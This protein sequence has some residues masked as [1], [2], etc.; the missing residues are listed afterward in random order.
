MP[1]V[2]LPDG[3]IVNFPDGMPEQEIAAAIQSLTKGDAPPQGG[4]LLDT[5]KNVGIGILKGA[6][7]SLAGIGE[8]AANA[9]AIPG[10]MPAAGNAAFRHPAFRMAESATTASND[11]QRAGKVIEGV[12]EVAVPAGAAI[13][14]IPRAGRAAAKFARVATAA[15][16]VPVNIEGPGQVALRIQQLGE[17]GAQEPRVIGKLLRRLTDPGKAPMDFEEARDFYSNVSRLS[18]NEFNSMNPI[19]Q[20]EMGNLRSAMN[21][22]LQDAAGSVGKGAEYGS[23]MKEYARAAKLKGMK[24]SLVD[25]LKRA[26]LPAG[27]AAGAYYWLKNQF[28][29][30]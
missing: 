18:A 8:L 2:H 7:S 27:G 30:E 4:G 11:A 17:R 10:V 5:A 26:A 14:A 29:G 16:K 3:R 9:G 12:A 21:T 25:G 19:V 6:G 15:N 24:E 28:G 23:A 22:S 13:N 1:R 20:R